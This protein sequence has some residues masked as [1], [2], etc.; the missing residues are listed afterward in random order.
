MYSRIMLAL[1]ALLLFCG[2]TLARQPSFTML[3]LRDRPAGTW[4]DTLAISHFWVGDD[5]IDS[6]VV[7]SFG[8]IPKI[9]RYL[10]WKHVTPQVDPN[11][12]DFAPRL[13]Q[14]FKNQQMLATRV[15]RWFVRNGDTSLEHLEE[16][17]LVDSFLLSYTKI[18]Y[19]LGD[20]YQ[21]ITEKYLYNDNRE[22]I[23][24]REELATRGSESD[25]QRLILQRAYDSHGRIRMTKIYGYQL[26]MFSHYDST[27]YY[28][29]SDNTLRSVVNCL[30]QHG[31][32]EYATSTL[33]EGWYQFEPETT[34]FTGRESGP[35]IG[36]AKFTVAT[37][38]SW[39]IGKNVWE[40]PWTTEKSYDQQGRL[41]STV[42]L[43]S[44][45]HLFSG[46]TTRYYPNGDLEVRFTR[47]AIEPD[48]VRKST[49]FENVYCD[50]GDLASSYE[51]NFDKIN[52]KHV[53]VYPEIASIDRIRGSE[54]LQFK[55]G[56]LLLN[57]PTSCITITDVTGRV[58]KEVQ[59]SSATWDVSTLR[60]GA[61]FIS[62]NGSAPMKYLSLGE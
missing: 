57:S 5:A 21:T 43:D 40:K 58:V 13:F 37:T 39:S 34:P 61:Y 38:S 35:P 42:I 27:T 55:D 32:P 62:V 56:K 23:E 4:S 6:L 24:H 18:R 53:F 41:F 26:H 19:D 60:S 54:N 25:T 10:N 44:L 9:E 46:D 15:E 29:N 14:Q 3:T 11:R 16:A 51:G 1:V 52:R 49:F 7:L 36:G 8:P 22:V 30:V 50:N 59:T 45:D 2:S 31:Q 48:S 17:T 20:V 28:Y 33:Y 12:L 47:Y